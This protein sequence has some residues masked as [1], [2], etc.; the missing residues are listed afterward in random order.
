M[1]VFRCLIVNFIT[2]NLGNSIQ[3]FGR[4]MKVLMLGWEFPPQITGGLGTA[5][6]GITKSLAEQKVKVLFVVPKTYG[7]EDNRYA[8]IQDAGKIPLRY[9]GVHSFRFWRNVRLKEVAAML[10]PYS[11]PEDYIQSYGRISQLSD[12]NEGPGNPDFEP[13]SGGYGSDLWKEV[14]RFRRVI[15]LLAGNE[16]FDIIHAHDWMTFPAAISAKEITGKP[17]IVHVHAT[18]FDRN[19]GSINNE[20]VKIEKNGMEQAD[21]IITVSNFTRDIIIEKY[22][23]K[24]DKVISIHNGIDKGNGSPGKKPGHQKREKIVTFLGR[25]TH[26]KGPEYFIEA[27]YRVLQKYNNVRFVM[28]GSGEMKDKIIGKVNR[29]G[30]ADR[31]TFPGFLDHDGINELFKRTD[32]FVMPSVS[33]PFGLSSLEAL[34]YSIPV[35]MSKQSGVSEV[36]KNAIKVDYW[37]IDALSDAISG[38]LNYGTLSDFLSTK[39]GEEVNGLKWEKTGKKIIE[40]YK[41]VIG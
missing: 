24:P 41:S 17:L 27:A 37:D 34:Q 20:I 7:D 19:S 38:I 40:V 1:C 36:I 8:T 29:L 30:I 26:Q 10:V 22:A 11:S 18:E 32:V 23:V 16:Q 25:L 3:G 6:Y 35:I 39:G 14:E 12:K 33:E 9:L 21:L 28:A 13:F 2:M 15:S 4:K 31:V 5:C